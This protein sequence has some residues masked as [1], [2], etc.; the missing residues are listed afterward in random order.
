MSGVFSFSGRKFI[1]GELPPVRELAVGDDRPQEV[2]I[3]VDKVVQA[4]LEVLLS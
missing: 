3:D 2:H 4:V 1:S